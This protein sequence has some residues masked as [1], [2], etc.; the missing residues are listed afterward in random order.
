MHQGKRISVVLAVYNGENYLAEALASLLAANC[1]DELI[2]SDDHSTDA[3]RS[4]VEA[5]ADPRIQLVCNDAGRGI[6]GNFNYGLR[7]AT[8]DV[9][10]LFSHDDIAH[11]GFLESQVDALL[12]SDLIGMAYASCHIVGADRTF[13][14]DIDDP[15]TPDEI[16][17]DHYLGIAARH[18]ALTP[19]VSTIMLK[20]EVLDTVGYFDP[21]YRVSGDLELA[22]RV[23]KSFLIGRNRAMKLDVREH[24]ESCTSN[25]E[26]QLRFMLEEMGIVD[27]FREHMSAADF[28]AA[29][30]DRL[31][32]R[33]ALHGKYLLRRLAAGSFGKFVEGTKALS[34]VHSP[35]ACFALAIQ[36]R[37]SGS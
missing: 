22:N 11:P 34:R 35:L 23:A 10:Q 27:Y 12:K 17:F 19:S 9:I 18:G 8:G 28:E 13:I 2:V 26:T 20:R 14:R 25:P 37:A 4:I 33:G 21:F 6:Y 31:R 29:M 30:R 7:H 5:A 24:A 36:E 16:A 1:L 32:I 3:T 15:G